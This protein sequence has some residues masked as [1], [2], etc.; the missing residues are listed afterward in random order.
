MSQQ[1]NSQ[2]QLPPLR[3]VL[4]EYVNQQGSLAVPRPVPGARP[5]SQPAS[6]P[7]PGLL[8]TLSFTRRTQ[9]PLARQ[10]VLVASC[11]SLRLRLLTPKPY[12][13]LVS[14]ALMIGTNLYHNPR[15]TP[16]TK[17]TWNPKTGQ[18]ESLRVAMYTH[19]PIPGATSR[20]PYHLTFAAIF[21]KRTTRLQE[22]LGQC[23]GLLRIQV[24]LELPL[25]GHSFNG[26][27]SPS[28]LRRIS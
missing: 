9:T 3:Q 25:V 7:R 2:P 20:T 18:G 17:R 27:S 28:K 12:Q 5:A 23:Q 26:I 4:P 22:S 19:A 1:K 16:T 8:G 14:T 15:A 24:H 6:A 13:R 11:M 21:V 10:R